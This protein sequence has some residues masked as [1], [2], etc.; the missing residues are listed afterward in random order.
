METADD[1]HPPAVA[2]TR[3]VEPPA[4]A[5]TIELPDGLHARNQ[6]TILLVEDEDIVRAALKRILERGGYSVVTAKNGE[7][8][9]QIFHANGRKF[10][11]VVTDVVMPHMNGPAFAREIV[12]Q[13][14]PI[15]RVLFVSGWPWDPETGF[16]PDQGEEIHLVSKPIGYIELI[17][18]IRDLLDKK[19]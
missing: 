14:W 17:Q 9:S 11:L 4:I 10:D 6:E 8:A 15:D 12:A 18:T 16:F 1:A 2:S 3:S 13:G 7:D 19:R 5:D